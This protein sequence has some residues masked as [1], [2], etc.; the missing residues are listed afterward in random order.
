MAFL[1][2]AELEESLLQDFERLGYER[3]TDAEIGPDGTSSGR[4]SYGDV[5]LQRRLVAAIEK[6]N[7]HIP[8]E[9][10]Q[11]AFKSLVATVTPS[12]VD[13][14]RRLHRFMVEGVG[15]EYYDTDGTVRPDTVR[16]IDFDTLELN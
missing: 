2:E 5:I 11:D 12:L 13:E 16:L 1:S 4:D 15:V 9:A 10:R 6:L 3:S 14:N 8:T 7:P